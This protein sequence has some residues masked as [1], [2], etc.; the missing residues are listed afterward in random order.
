MAKT[1]L[2]LKPGDK[3]Y[4]ASKG[5]DGYHITEG[6]VISNQKEEHKTTW[7]PAWSPEEVILN[8]DTLKISF[9]GILGVY[10][11]VYVPDV[12][13]HNN[14]SLMM[15]PHFSYPQPNTNPVFRV[16]TDRESAVE[17][18]IKMAE[19]VVAVC[20]EK[21]MSAN[22]ELDMANKMLQS[23]ILEK[24]TSKAQSCGNKNERVLL[25]LCDI[26]RDMPLMET[27][28]RAHG[29]NVEETLE[30]INHFRDVTKMMD[31]QENNSA[32]MRHTIGYLEN[33]YQAKNGH[34][35]KFKV[36]DRIYCKDDSYAR[37]VIKEVHD[38]YYIN[39]FAQRMDMSYTDANFELIEHL[40][41]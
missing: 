5:R 17:Y 11:Q 9:D 36:G 21:V 34:T 39:G 26:I 14:N 8:E 30:Y 22:D 37:Y 13:K 40:D 23:A 33:A 12:I 1:F 7:G 31:G 25:A 2:T 35:P 27:E 3:V 41:Q 20:E 15:S 19:S 24:E 6:T 29:L 18:N 16:F 4:G 32:R 28:L 10:E 38:N